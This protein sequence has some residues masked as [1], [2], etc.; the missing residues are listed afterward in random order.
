MSD[1]VKPTGMIKNPEIVMLKPGPN[2][3]NWIEVG[4]LTQH[5]FRI[6]IVS[7]RKGDGHIWQSGYI[8]KEELEKAR[9]QGF[10]FQWLSSGIGG[11]GSE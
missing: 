11:H 9:I 3:Q 2:Y 6:A 8:T 10:G 4:E 1:K 5:G 7:Y